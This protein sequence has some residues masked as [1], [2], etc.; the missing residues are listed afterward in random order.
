MEN[1]LE[2]IQMF[3]EDI[4]SKIFEYNEERNNNTEVFEEFDPVIYGASPRTVTSKYF[5]IIR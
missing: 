1:R 3:I 2:W 4:L 5:D